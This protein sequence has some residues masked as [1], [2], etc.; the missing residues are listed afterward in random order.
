MVDRCD[1]CQIHAPI[2]RLLKTRLTSIMSPWSFYQWGLDILGPLPKG[3]GKLKFIIV[4]IDYF[5][6]WMEAKP[7]AKTT[8]FRTNHSFGEH[9]VHC[10]E[11][12]G[13]KYRHDMVR[14]V[15]FDICMRVEISAKKEAPVN[16]LTDPSDERSTFKPADVLVFGWVEGKHACVDLTEVSPLVGLSNRGFTVGQAALK[17]ALEKVTKQEK[18]CIENQY[19]FIH[20]VFDT[21]G[22]FAPEAVELLSQ[23]QRVMHSNVMTPRSPDVIFKRIGFVIQ[24]GLAAQLVAR[25]PFTTM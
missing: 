11:L 19:V 23:V 17:A 6:K 4:V 14:D 18:S 8:A 22:F 3:P 2:P 9:A 10:K 24:K 20:F 21:F 1:S 5:T 25:L 15:F 13:F 7:L 16:F 12:P